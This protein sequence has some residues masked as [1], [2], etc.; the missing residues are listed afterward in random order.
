MYRFCVGF[1]GET[2][3]VTKYEKK[4]IQSIISNPSAKWNK[5]FHQ[6]YVQ[7]VDSELNKLQKKVVKFLGKVDTDMWMPAFKCKSYI[8]WE[9]VDI[10]KFNLPFQDMKVNIFLGTFKRR[11]RNK[12]HITQTLFLQINSYLEL[13]NCVVTRVTL[14]RVLQL[15][16]Y[17]IVASWCSW[18]TVRQPIQLPRNA[19]NKILI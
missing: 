19:W 17:Y 3:A 14:K 11:K 10:L 12:E 1:A 4:L 13:S 8:E 16:K 9:A 7:S 15:A 5:K 6:A 18:A 2:E